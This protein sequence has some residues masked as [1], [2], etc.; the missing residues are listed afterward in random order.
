MVG[1]LW[2]IG[3]ADGGYYWSG[4]PVPRASF[5]VAVVPRC[6]K[7]PTPRHSDNSYCYAPIHPHNYPSSTSVGELPSLQINRTVAVHCVASLKYNDV[8]SIMIQFL[9]GFI[10]R[11]LWWKGGVGTPRIIIDFKINHVTRHA[12]DDDAAMD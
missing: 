3:A 5:V 1:C 2:G 11:D 10:S 6:F 9:T 4:I 12:T 8:L 7:L